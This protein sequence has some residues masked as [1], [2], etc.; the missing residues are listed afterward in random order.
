M[1]LTY[2]A[3]LRP[4]LPVLLQSA[5]KSLVLRSSPAFICL[6]QYWLLV[7]HRKHLAASVPEM[8]LQALWQ[9]AFATQSD[10]PLHTP[11][12]AEGSLEIAAFQDLFALHAAYNAILLTRNFDRFPPL[13]KAIDWHLANTQPDHVTADPWALAALQA[14]IPPAPSPSSNF[15]PRPPFWPIRRRLPLP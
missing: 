6:W 9:R 14:L 3:A 4:D 13:Q 10:G 5:Q 12:S 7:L 15:T 2:Q 11:A 8:L 1:R